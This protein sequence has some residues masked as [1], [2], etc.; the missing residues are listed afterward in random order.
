MNLI[1]SIPQIFSLPLY[2][3]DIS[4]ILER[5]RFTLSYKILF[6]YLFIFYFFFTLSNA[7]FGE[8]IVFYL[9]SKSL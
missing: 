3:F 1:V 8:S 6:F 7:K 5:Y 9:I 4:S 2:Q